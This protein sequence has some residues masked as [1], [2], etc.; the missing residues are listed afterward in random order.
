MNPLDRFNVALNQV[1]NKKNIAHLLA[2]TVDINR[3]S[4]H[5]GYCKP[6]N[7]AL[8]LDAKL[9]RSVNTRL[10]KIDRAEVIDRGVV[11]DVL[12]STPLGTAIGRMKRQSVVLTYSVRQVHVLVVAVVKGYLHVSHSPVHFICGCV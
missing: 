3:P 5:R 8:I 10:S 4:C 7:P 11:F 2:I 1:I 6:S 12:V 9:S